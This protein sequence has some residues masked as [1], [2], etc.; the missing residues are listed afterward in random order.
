[1]HGLTPDQIG[2]VVGGFIVMLGALVA[3]I[4]KAWSALSSI[5]D[6]VQHDHGHSMKDASTR[7][8]EKVDSLGTG[9]HALETGLGGIRDE[10]RLMRRESAQTREEVADLRTTSDATHRDLK[11]GQEGLDR[12]LDAIEQAAVNP[13]GGWDYQQNET[14]KGDNS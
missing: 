7:T 2:A 13:C 10:L 5:R 6:E 9:L 14:H 12:R 4:G 8:E 1:M 11:T 3:V